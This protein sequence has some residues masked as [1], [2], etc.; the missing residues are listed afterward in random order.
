MDTMNAAVDRQFLEWLVL[1]GAVLGGGGGGSLADGR[2]LADAALDLGQPRLVSL[3]A[4]ADDDLVVTVS[5]VGAP[6]DVERHVEPSDH[7]DALER[8]RALVPA[9]MAGVIS[10]ENGAASSVNGFVQSAATGVP[11]VDA[12]ADGR[13]HPTGI[14]GSMGLDA[15][16]GYRSRQVALG[17]D[18]ARGRRIVPVVEAPL[19]RADRLVRQAAIE[20]GGMVAVAR[21]PIEAAYVRTHGAPGALTEAA[22]L[23]RAASEALPYGAARVA[24]AL[25]ASFGAG[26]VL[27]EAAVR[28][29][30]RQTEGGYDV[31]RIE[32]DSFEVTF[33]NEYMTVDQGDQRLATFPDLI[34]TLDRDTGLPLGSADLEA[35]RTVLL[36]VVP[37]DRLLLGAGVRDRRNF[38]AI[39]RVLHRPMIRYAFR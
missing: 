9:P 16:P 14:M 38:A 2:R 10:S 32:V 36:L 5:A 13:A 19:A 1:G 12:P 28:A 27:A 26:K 24:D 11:V 7:V 25:L 33:W 34:V 4:L 3:D 39:E 21:N 20:A 22:R 8:L 31:G 30:E 17:G 35:G 37:K 23:G 18:P 6:A 15:V 29:L